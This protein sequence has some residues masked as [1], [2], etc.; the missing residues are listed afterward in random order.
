M[1]IAS[2]TFSHFYCLENKNEEAFRADLIAA[3]STF[4]RLD[5]DT[6]SII[7]CRNQYNDDHLK[8]AAKMGF[9]AFRGNEDHFVHRPRVR[10]SLLVRGTRLFDNYVNIIGNHLTSPMQNNQGLCNIPSSRF[11]RPC[12]NNTHIERM[13]LKR[14]KNT[15]LAAAKEAKGFHLWWHPHNFGAD[16]LRNINFLTEIL[17]YYKFL[18]IEYGMRSLSM[19][20]ISKTYS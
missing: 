9:K 12:S 13:R 14:I 19:S 11:L 3:L 1:E 8:I 18:N 17:N 10:H 7:F 4:R 6:E 5:I 15:M 20:E 2:H 16:V